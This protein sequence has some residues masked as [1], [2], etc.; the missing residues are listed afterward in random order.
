M[1]HALALGRPIPEAIANAPELDPSLRV[2]WN[3]FFALQSCRA[4]GMTPGPIPWTAI[5]AY[6]DR[7]E[8]HG[9][10]REDMHQLL[11]AMD[12]EY[13]GYLA[14]RSKGGRDGVT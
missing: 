10:A 9:E 14:K 3:A 1:R 12:S 6:C 13:L 11:R 8:L 4:I 7:Y 2:F 5:E